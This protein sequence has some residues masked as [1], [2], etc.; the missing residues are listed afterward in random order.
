[1][2]VLD[3]LS[4]GKR[5]NLSGVNLDKVEFI[6]N[7]LATPGV[8]SQAVAG[9]SHV[10]H[11]GA[12][13]SVPRS[14]EDPVKTHRV[15]VD[16]TLL[17]LMAA[18]DADVERMVFSSSSSVYGDTKILPKHEEMIPNPLSPYA[19]QKLMGERYL[20]LA[21]RLYGLD[22]V[23]LRFFN[24]FGPRQD[25]LS[26]YSGVISLFTADLSEGRVPTIY[27]DGEQTRDFTYVS[28]VVDGVLAACNASDVSGQVI[29][30]ARGGRTSLN[31]LFGILRDLIGSD[32]TPK[33]GPP[34]KGD[35]IDSQ[36]D[37]VRAREL[38]RFKSKV[39]LEE[40]LHRT[41]KWYVNSNFSA[42]LR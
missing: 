7:D 32:V 15:N 5:E 27:G 18:R 40:G 24:V 31:R 20:Q 9:I 17:L 10:I 28:D 1:V 39:S 42:H 22:T 4:T 13:P 41:I 35:V 30:L 16:G 34:R 25:P 8:A 12:I 38:L 19:L 36:A 2:R 26:M 37:V 21:Y 14:I 23:S 6:E 11:I 3:D 29:N 33:Y